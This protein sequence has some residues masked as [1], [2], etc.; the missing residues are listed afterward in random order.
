MLSKI[1]YQQLW[2][3]QMRTNRNPYENP[4]AA[5]SYDNSLSIWEDG[6]KRAARMI[7]AEPEDTVLDIGCGPGVLS[8]P[9]ARRVCQVTAIDPSRAMLGLLRVHQ[10]EERLSNIRIIEGHWEEMDYLSLGQFDLVIASYS[11]HMKD[12]CRALSA[13]N[14]AAKKRVYLYW[15]CGMTS[16]EKIC[17][18]LYPIVYNKSFSLYPKAELLYGMLSEMGISANVTSLADTA[19]D[20]VYPTMKDAIVNMRNRLGLETCDT[21][22]DTV[23]RKYIA[24]NYQSEGEGWRFKDKSNYV[25]IM[26]EPR[27][28]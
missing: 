19:F 9:L 7:E 21:R 1:G 20:H 6:E 28:E 15:F 8:I 17:H 12:M 4:E 2:L 27:S 5:R 23:F 26:W 24:N 14:A 18:D 11:L 25:Q 16:W 10:Y 22:Y 13:M 3:E